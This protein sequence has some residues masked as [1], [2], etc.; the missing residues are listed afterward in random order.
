MFDQ[1]EARPT[2]F[3]SVPSV[4]IQLPDNAYVTG[5]LELDEQ[6]QGPTFVGKTRINLNEETVKKAVEFWLTSTI[7]QD[8]VTVTAFKFAKAKEGEAKHYAVEFTVNEREPVEMTG[9]TSF[10]L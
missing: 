6:V 7:F 5:V 9:Q 1:F 3:D 10:D 8:D 2:H 4:H